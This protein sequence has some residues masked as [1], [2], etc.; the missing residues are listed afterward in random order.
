M[1]LLLFAQVNDVNINIV[2][3][4]SPAPSSQQS[5]LGE[6]LN[7]QRMSDIEDDGIVDL[8]T[9]DDDVGD[10][11]I[12]IDLTAG[13][14]DT[15][16]DGI[17]IDLA[18]GDDDVTTDKI[19]DGISELPEVDDSGVLVD[20]LVK[21]LNDIF[22]GKKLRQSRAIVAVMCIHNETSKTYI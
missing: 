16:D 19:I 3:H 10:D 15:G 13:D 14:D 5:Y 1:F 17:I 8:A 7:D 2:I 12:S 18:A 22:E 21:E 4:A 6:W 11:S 9:G 20:E